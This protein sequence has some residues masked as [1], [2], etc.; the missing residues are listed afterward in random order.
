VTDLQ[1]RVVSRALPGAAVLWALAIAAAPWS[2]RVPDLLGVP[3]LVG[4]ATYLAGAVVCHQRPERS[5]H[6]HGAQWPVC[7]RCTGLYLS[8]AAGVLMAWSWRRRA[9]NIPFRSWRGVLL[10]ASVPTVATLVLEWLDSNWSSDFAR[11]LAAA[12]L[13][14]A[15]GALLAASMSFQ[16]RLKGCRPT[17]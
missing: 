8:A 12:P 5:F 11:A 14:G 16:G 6:A 10:A 7:A 17:R 13:G 1:L 4:G 2:G 3:R 15:V 9:I